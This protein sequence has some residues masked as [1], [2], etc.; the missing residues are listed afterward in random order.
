MRIN[1]NNA[2]LKIRE[3]MLHI[4][5]EKNEQQR[6]IKQNLE[7]EK[8]NYEKVSKGKL[9]KMELNYKERLQAQTKN[10]ETIINAKDKDI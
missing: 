7:A 10:F 1:E 4:M 8:N 5:G 9:Q 3:E 6:K 2:S